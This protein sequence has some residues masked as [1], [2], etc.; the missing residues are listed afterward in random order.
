MASAVERGVEEFG[1]TYPAH[2]R[3]G[4]SNTAYSSWNKANGETIE[5]GLPIDEEELDRIDMSHA[6]YVMLMEK[7]L[8]LAPII[9]NPQ[10]VL[11]L[12]TGTGIWAISV[13][14]FEQVCRLLLTCTTVR[15]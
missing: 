5:Y 15:R 4:M 8:F 6:K 11:D 7:K 10:K 9:S 1:R 14:K 2:R 12:G 3:E 13:R